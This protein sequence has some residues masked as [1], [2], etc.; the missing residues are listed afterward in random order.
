MRCMRYSEDVFG[1]FGCTFSIC[2]NVYFVA[3]GVFLGL[4]LV[5]GGFIFGTFWCMFRTLV[6]YFVNVSSCFYW[7]LVLRED[8]NG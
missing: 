5:C 6:V 7:R 8:I 2:V 1:I 4:V 3:V